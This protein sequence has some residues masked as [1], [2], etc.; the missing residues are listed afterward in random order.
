M[1]SLYKEIWT[2]LGSWH[3]TP[4]NYY[5]A[6]CLQHSYI[7]LE[8]SCP[9]D[10]IYIVLHLVHFSVLTN[11][12]HCFYRGPSIGVRRWL[13][14]LAWTM[15]PLCPE[16]QRSWDPERRLRS[17][18][19]SKSPGPDLNLDTDTIAVMFFCFCGFYS[20]GKHDKRYYHSLTENT[21]KARGSHAKYYTSQ[22]LWLFFF[23]IVTVN[24]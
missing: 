1:M 10:L 14:W 19:W 24:V 18:M 11:V 22:M 8:L 16:W 20:E 4:G 6:L 23:A 9:K 12:P 17:A 7:K 15:I 3:F 21:H 13:P 2:N 5:F